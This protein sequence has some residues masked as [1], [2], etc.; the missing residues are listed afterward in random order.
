MNPILK[1][2]LSTQSFEDYEI[3]AEWVRDY[4]GAASL[5]ARILYDDLTAELD[6]L[7]P[8]AS[9]LILTGPLTGTFGPATGR[10]IVV[11]KSPA[12]RLW[13]ESNVGGFWGIELRKTG[14]DGIWLTGKSDSPLYLWL[15]GGKPELRAADH[16]WG[17]DTYQIQESLK[18]ETGSKSAKVLGIGIAGEKQTPM[19]GIFCDHGRAAGRTG[20]GAVMGSK[21]LKAIAVQGS[22]EIPLA[23]PEKYKK[24]RMAANRALKEDPLTGVMSDLGSAGAAEYLDYLGEMPKKYFSTGTLEGAEKISGSSVAETLLVGTKACHGCVIACGRVVDIDDGE[25]RKGPEYE[26]LVGFGP[27]LGLTDAIFATRMSELCDRYGLD[28]I[29]ASGTMGLAYSLYE[30]GIIS[31]A[32]TGGLALKWGNAEAAEMLLHQMARREGFGGLLAQGSL[33]LARHFDVESQAIQV[34]GLE[35]AY[36]DPRGASGMA[37]VYAVSPRGA[38]HNQSDYFL[39]DIGQVD[40]ALGLEFFDRH[41]GAEKAANV[42]RHQ[43]WRTVGNALVLCH[44]ANVPPNTILDLV[45]AALGSDWDLDVLMRAG[46]RGWNLKRMINLNLGLLPS[47]DRLPE[48]LLQPLADGGAAGYEIPFEKMLSAYY[49]ARSWDVES[50]APT[51]EKLQALGLEDIDR[52]K[53]YERG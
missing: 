22:A 2:N 33:A 48:P 40:D 50:G 4:L 23:E 39:A 37:L 34:N 24:L 26:A 12:T 49:T 41:A 44:F 28:L 17:Q 42:A 53:Q 43:D 29:S 6:P 32:D 16:L 36:H 18:A 20:L 31:G 25:K 51:H 14:Y 19:A 38:C 13:A 35:L 47:H 27:N 45:N 11:G 1:I 7:S 46:E 8:A 30:R 15:N 10:F 52:D 21:N 3:P 9:L 5:A